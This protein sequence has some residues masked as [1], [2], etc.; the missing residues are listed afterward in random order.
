MVG[1]VSITGYLYR[2][3]WLQLFIGLSAHVYVY[4]CERVYVHMRMSVS[5]LLYIS[6]EGKK[7]KN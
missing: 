7:A 3:G 5:V 1:N 4:G 2:S 6:Q